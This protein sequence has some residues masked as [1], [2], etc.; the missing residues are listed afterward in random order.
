M[1]RFRIKV[2]RWVGYSATIYY[3]VYY[4]NSYGLFWREVTYFYEEKPAIEYAKSLKN[5]KHIPKK[6]KTN[7]VYEKDWN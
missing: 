4:S 3:T 7:I 5:V 1:K 6:K 2:K